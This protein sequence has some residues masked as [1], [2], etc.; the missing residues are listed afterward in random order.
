[1][2]TMHQRSYS[3]IS[4]LRMLF[5]AVV[6][7]T[8]QIPLADGRLHTTL[9]YVAGFRAADGSPGGLVGTVVD[10]IRSPWCRSPGPRVR[11]RHRCRW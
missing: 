4:W 5:S 2:L 9:Y 3:I 10:L 11:P 8:T 1:M 7:R 6:R